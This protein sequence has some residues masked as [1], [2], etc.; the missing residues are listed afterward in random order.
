[1]GLPSASSLL[2]PLAQLSTA[3]LCSGGEGKTGTCASG[4][5]VLHVE[6]LLRCSPS[7]LPRV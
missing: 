5:G 7:A 3:G 1:M 2:H 6:D 4:V